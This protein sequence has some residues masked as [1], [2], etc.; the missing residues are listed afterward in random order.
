MEVV[1]NTET[2][3]I[4]TEYVICEVLGIKFN[5]SRDYVKDLNFAVADE[6]FKKLEFLK[7]IGICEH[8]GNQNDSVG[9]FRLN[10]GTFLSV[11]TNISG[12]KV[13]PNFIGQTTLKKLNFTS[14]EDYKFWTLNS[15]GEAFLKYSKALLKTEHLLYINYSAGKIFY[16]THQPVSLSNSSFSFTK[17]LETWKESCTMKIDGKSIAEFQVHNNRNCVKCRFSMSNF[18]Q[19]F[20]R[21]QAYTFSKINFKIKKKV[22]TFNYLGSKTKLLS[23]LRTSIEEYTTKPLQEISTFFDLFAGSGA[24]SA[25]FLENGVKNIVTND[26]MYYSK[27]LSSG[28]ICDEDISKDIDILN[29]LEPSRG[30]IT[31]TYATNRMYFTEDNAMRIDAIREYLEYNKEL[32]GDKKFHILLRCLLYASTKVANISSTYGAYLKK[33]KPSSSK[34][35]TLF[36]PDVKYCSTKL[37]NYNDSILNLVEYLDISGDVCYLDPPYNSRKYSSN[38]FVMELLAT[39]CKDPVSNGITGVP[40]TEPQGSS[41]FCSKAKAIESFSKLFSKISTKYLFLSYS[42]EALLSKETI[43]ELLS[44]NGWCEVEIKYQSYQRFSSNK[45]TKNASTDLE[46]YLFCAKRA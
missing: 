31:E 15:P 10:D 36:C 33:F 37:T 8:I 12:D 7:N 24:V 44:S 6:L 20:T 9:D 42:S 5:S 46:E 23:F 21:H 2:I 32:I 13:C 30:F 34:R 26:N 1:E 43:L 25:Y 14:P 18:I 38:Y 29:N 35:I 4:W 41:D 17:T 22:G 3:G 11:K 19:K 39:N 28:M 16:I 45:K 40:L 27:V